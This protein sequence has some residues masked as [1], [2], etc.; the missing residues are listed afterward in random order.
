MFMNFCDRGRDTLKV[1]ST[2]Q[3]MK[4][5]ITGFFSKCDQIRCFL[6]ILSHLL[7]TSVMEN[8]IFCAVKFLECGGVEYGLEI[9]VI[10]SFEGHE[11]AIV[12]IPSQQLHVQS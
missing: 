11:K 7:K 8:F 6:R 9:P 10:Y 3:K 12:W 2:A 1:L 4:F 5:S